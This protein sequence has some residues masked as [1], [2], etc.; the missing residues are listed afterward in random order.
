[1]KVLL[2]SASPRRRDL[3]RQIGWEA[4]IRPVDFAERQA[5]D[6]D[7]VCLGNA[8][9]KAA[10]AAARYGDALPV[11]AADTIV[12]L[13]GAV[14]GKPADAAGARAM[15]RALSGRTHAVKTAVAVRWRGQERV[16]V[17]TTVVTFRLLTDE[18]I[19][20]YVATGEPMDKAGAYGIQGKGALLVSRI[21]GAYDNVVGLPRT[22]VYTILQGLGAL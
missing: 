14:L 18:E 12:T 16:A 4:V 10:D 6:P 5:G 3:L 2:A 7:A 13:D 15:L 11:V 17:A 20:A 9:G 19:E 21:D 1:M 22:L 8:R